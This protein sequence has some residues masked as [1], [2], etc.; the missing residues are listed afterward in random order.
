MI[1]LTVGIR[2]MMSYLK[3]GMS[4]RH[5]RILFDGMFFVELLIVIE[6]TGSV[7]IRGH[8]SYDTFL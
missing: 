4:P 2:S 6:E 7:Q 5:V 3:Y 1:D 8:K